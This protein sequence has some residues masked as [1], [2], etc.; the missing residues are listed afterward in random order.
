MMTRN[1]DRM[2]DMDE[3][4]R[5]VEQAVVELATA[6]RYI[7]YLVLVIGASVGIDVGALM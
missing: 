2:N 7:K 6:T 1:D 3:R 4:L 5:I